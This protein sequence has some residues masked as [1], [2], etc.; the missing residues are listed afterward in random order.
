VKEHL[1]KD[2]LIPRD[3][4]TRWNSTF[5]MLSTGIEY[6]VAIDMM[7]SDRKNGLRELE[8]SAEEWG[9][10]TQLRDILK[11]APGMTRSV[12]CITDDGL[13]SSRMRLRI[14]LAMAPRTG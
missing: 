11:V 2:K 7:A 14:F 4:S 3:V 10:A 6:R 13:R 5:D 12:I 1:L 9:I 8:L